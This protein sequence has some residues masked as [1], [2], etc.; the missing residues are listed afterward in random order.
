MAES[1]D[2]PSGTDVEDAPSATDVKTVETVATS[3][4]DEQEVCTAEA[5]AIPSLRP[6]EGAITRA[7]DGAIPYLPASGLDSGHL[8][9]LKVGEFTAQR[10]L[11]PSDSGETLEI[12]AGGVLIAQVNGKLISRTH[13][14]M[15]SSGELGF[16]PATR[17]IRG[18]Q[19]DE[20]FGI[21]QEKLFLVTG[22]G[23]MVASARGEVFT[24]LRLEDD[25]VYLREEYVFAFEPGLRWENGRVPGT[26]FHVAQFRGH[27]CLAIRT[28][29]ELLSVRLTS[30]RVMYVESGV[31]AGWIG[32]VVP[33]FVKP[34]AGGDSSTSFI[35]CSGEGVV[36][37]HDLQ[38]I[39]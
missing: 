35:E 16:E 32:K 36:L 14:V 27:G 2:A 39:T 20:I 26:N 3:N 25:I 31:I 19:S 9:P 13:G 28:P 29:K 21:G 38:A 37:M 5:S 18:Q 15:V 22:Q 17:R 11:R 1:E 33:R 30:E 7:V 8:P 34:A 24:A 23:Y 6:E 12:G 10:L 4:S